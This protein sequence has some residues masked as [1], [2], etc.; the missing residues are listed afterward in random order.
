MTPHW[1]VTVHR[2]AE[3]EL[4]ALKIVDPCLLEEVREAMETLACEPDPR[5]P[6]NP[7]LNVCALKE[8][9][10]EWFRVRTMR[11]PQARVIFRLLQKRGAK[12]VEVREFGWLDREASEQ[13]LQIVHAGTRNIVYRGL[14]NLH[15][16]LRGTA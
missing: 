7:R 8:T 10:G 1:K 11:G 16:R 14:S 2:E 12:I 9:H 4:R 13:S 6:R 15:K 5:R 3:R